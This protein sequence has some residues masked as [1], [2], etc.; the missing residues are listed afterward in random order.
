MTAHPNAERPADTDAAL[1][2]WDDLPEIRAE[3]MIGDWTGAEVPT[4][5]PMDGLLAAARW[6]GKRFVSEEEV[7]PLIH[8]DGAGRLY[9]ANP[10]RIPFDEG[11]MGSAPR[12]A[13]GQMLFA[14]GQ[15]VHRTRRPHARLRETR[16]RGALTATMIYDQ[17]PIHDVFKRVND[18]TVLGLM[19][20][21]GMARP[22]FFT[23]ERA[24]APFDL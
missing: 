6:H 12:G 21:R 20:M 14:M 3:E 1:A 18:R 7:Y 16:H 15:P 19:D 13:L 17:R 22:Y 2:W 8:R 10:G 4:G 11:L 23:L 9:A 5:H 24:E